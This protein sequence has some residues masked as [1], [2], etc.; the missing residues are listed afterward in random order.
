M[1]ELEMPVPCTSCGRMAELNDMHGGDE[2]Y[3]PT[4]WP[5]VVADQEW[6]QTADT[7]GAQSETEW[8]VEFEQTEGRG[9]F[10]SE[11]GNDERDAREHLADRIKTDRGVRLVARRVICGPWE[12]R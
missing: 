8:G 12:A 3:C 9:R 10:V 1:S 4:C 2:L 6:E 11:W 7:L 5:E